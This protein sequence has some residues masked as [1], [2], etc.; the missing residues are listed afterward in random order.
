MAETR[1]VLLGLGEKLSFRLQDI[2][3]RKNFR[4]VT[5]AGSDDVLLKVKDTAVDAVFLDWK[6]IQPDAA[7]IISQIRES[8]PEL[9][10]IVIS[11]GEALPEARKELARDGLICLAENVDDYDLETVITRILER[12]YLLTENSRLLSEVRNLQTH[13]QKPESADARTEELQREKNRYD[14]VMNSLAQGIIVIDK[15]RRIAIINPAAENLLEVESSRL[16]GRLVPT[17]GVIPGF[18]ILSEIISERRRE[19]KPIRVERRRDSP[20]E[21]IWA[22]EVET[23]QPKKMTLRVTISPMLDENKRV[24]GSVYQLVNITRE[25]ELD[26]MK[27]D[28]VSLVSHELRTPLTSILGFVSLLLSGKGGEI[29]EQQREILEKVKRQSDRLHNLITDLLDISRLERGK[30]TLEDELIRVDEIARVRIE[31]MRPPAD[32]KGIQIALQAPETIPQVVG[33]SARIGQV[34]INLIG[35]AIK[36][37]RPAGKITVRIVEEKGELLVQVTD[38][39]PGIPRKELSK[40]FDKFY[41]V[42]AMATRKEGG[43][44]LG[45]AIAK[46]IVEA[47]HGK[48]WV[49]SEMDK[50]T[51][52]SFTLPVVGVA[53]PKPTTDKKVVLVVDDEAD[54][55]S[56]IKLALESEKVKVETAYDG[57]SALAKAAQI[58]PDLILL[59]VMMPVFDGFSVCGKLKSNPET[60]HIPV[61]IFTGTAE[62]YI[63]KKIKKAGADDYILKPI[64]PKAL[65]KKV[66]AFL[67]EER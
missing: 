38:S 27:I 63:T 48:M 45:L 42:G 21:R 51:R 40:I 10:T 22:K 8:R 50:Y 36:Y 11:P 4:I 23:D 25:K 62:S 3:Q 53:P 26:Q 16:L 60:K 52:F 59:D 33:D 17:S 29:T 9:F 19:S 47:H 44:G 65:E 41:Q 58:K 15:E 20:Q 35:N 46:G 32:A 12:Q 2:S 43:T 1:F 18:A 7:E 66:S 6:S 5:A 56:M 34:L 55:L 13:L 61:I 28:F 57:L 49:E 64:E 54:V 24:L 30:L 31:E 67:R 14:A 39:G 37:S